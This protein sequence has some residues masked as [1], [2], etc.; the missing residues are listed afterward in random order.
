MKKV[1]FKIEDL[2]LKIFVGFLFAFGVLVC[3]SAYAEE[4]PTSTPD[5]VE[6]EATTS[7]PDVI[8]EP[9]VVPEEAST[10][11]PEESVGITNQVMVN[12]LN[13]EIFNGQVQT[14]STWFTDAGGQD[15]FSSSTSALGVLMQSARE[16]NFSV[17]VQDYGYGHYVSAIDGNI[18]QGFDGWIYNINQADPGWVGTNDYMIQDGDLLTVF[19]SV[20]PWKVESNVTSTTLGEDVVFTAYNYASSTWDISP[21]TTISI[22]EELFE[23]DFNGQCNYMTT[24]TGTISA[25]IYGDEAWPT[26]SPTINVEVLATPE[27]TTTTTEPKTTTEEGKKEEDNKD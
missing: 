17:E 15:Y 1:N 4:M 14:T 19:Y 22:N 8:L 16:G 2:R 7:T 5:I 26:N 13:Q 23:T 12:Y 18:A 21:S 25:F 9:E 11:T 24:A 10:S 27:T 20:W 6:P 3:F